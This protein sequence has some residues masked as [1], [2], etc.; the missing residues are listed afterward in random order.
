MLMSGSKI[1]NVRIQPELKEKA[2]A[3]A[4]ADGRSL[5]NWIRRLIKEQVEE[6]ERSVNAYSLAP[7]RR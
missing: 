4:K 3:L 1:V 7:G 5:S 6:A 2:R